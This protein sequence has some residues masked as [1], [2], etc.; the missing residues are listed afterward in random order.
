MPGT[1]R[2]MRLRY[3]GVCS[4]C[5]APL[6]AGTVGVYDGVSKTVRCMPHDQTGA[7]TLA[8][9]PSDPAQV[10]AARDTGDGGRAGASAQREYERRMKRREERI[11]QAHP[12][13]PGQPT[14]GFHDPHGARLDM[15]RSQM[16]YP[17]SYERLPPTA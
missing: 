6:P 2:T 3:A 10:P 12:R 16:L 9:A 15:L 8:P 4:E 17:L 14:W 11:R 7:G 13:T 1:V 5:A